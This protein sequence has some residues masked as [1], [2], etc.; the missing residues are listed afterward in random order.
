MRR[1]DIYQQNEQLVIGYSTKVESMNKE[2]EEV[3]AQ[4]R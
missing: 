4:C 2:V 1:E 3:K